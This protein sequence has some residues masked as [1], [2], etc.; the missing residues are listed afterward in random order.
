MTLQL[1]CVHINEKL[2]ECIE[3]LMHVSKFKNMRTIEFGMNLVLQNIY[4]NCLFKRI[5]KFF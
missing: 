2:Q 3:F 1:Y 4:I 5:S